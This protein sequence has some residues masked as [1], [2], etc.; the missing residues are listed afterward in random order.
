MCTYYKHVR[1]N[2]LNR[3]CRETPDAFIGVR[4]MKGEFDDHL[5]WPFNGTVTIKI[6]YECLKLCAY[7][8][9]CIRL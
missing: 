6:N 1:V 4:L 3:T 9:T 7:Q 5:K 8:Y 2:S